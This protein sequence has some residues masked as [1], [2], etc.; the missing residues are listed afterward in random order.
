MTACVNIKKPRREN[1]EDTEV[2]EVGDVVRRDEEGGRWCLTKPD[3]LLLADDWAGKAT[4]MMV[5]V[6]MMMMMMMMR[7]REIARGTGRTDNERVSRRQEENKRER[8]KNQGKKEGE[9]T[10]Y[11]TSSQRKRETSKSKKR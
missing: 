9:K 4:L 3:L 6:V 7:M 1:G 2:G 5:M 11:Y 10:N 8:N